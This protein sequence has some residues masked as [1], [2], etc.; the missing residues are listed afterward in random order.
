MGRGDDLRQ[1][2]LTI[3]PRALG[4]GRIALALVLLL[5]LVRR[6]PFTGLWYSNLG[7]LPNHTVLWRPPF[8]HVFSL[9][10]TASRPFEAAVGFGLCGAAYV[11]LLLGIRTRWAQVA[12]LLA[13]LS[14]H[15]RVLFIQNSGDV[16]LGELCLWTLFLPLGRCWSVDAL[17]AQA[18]D[19]RA[20]VVSWAVLALSGQLAVIYLFNAAQKN[21]RTWTEG[22]AVHY[23]LYYANVVTT[24]GVWLRSWITPRLSQVLTWSTRATEALLPILVLAP[25]AQRHARRLAI[26]LDRGAPRRLRA[27]PEPGDLRAGDAGVRAL[28]GAGRRLGSP[29]ASVDANQAGCLDPRRG[30]APGERGVRSTRG[31]GQMAPFARGGGAGA[32][33]RGRLR[34]PGRQRGGHAHPGLGRTARRER[35]ARVPSNVPVLVA[36]CAR[37]SDHGG[38][39]RGRRRHGGRPPRRSFERSAFGARPW[40]GETIPPALGNNGFASAYLVRL[41]TRPE[42]FTALG[43]WLLRYP[44]RTGRASDRIVSFRVLGL[45]QDDPPPGEHDPR[46]PRTTLLF[47]YPN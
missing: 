4:A 15:G 3:D 47:R 1:K 25:V 33:G 20:P 28:S 8:P 43:E 38:D 36:L 31:R 13:V 37:R 6:V 14:L 26:A 22:T 34:Q 27:V 11:M 40:L 44:E 35:P 5:D 46:N 12:S 7:L 19:Q 21:G 42:Y 45:E 39:H 24:P 18:A 2:Y 23:V 32:D 16:V 30:R 29:P 9:F 17:R 41:P 10:F